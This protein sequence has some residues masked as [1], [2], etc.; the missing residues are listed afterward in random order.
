MKKKALWKDCLQ[1]IRKTFPKFLSIL[2]I[3]FLGIAFFAGIRAT[4]PDMI[5]TAQD[6]YEQQALADIHIMSTMGLTEDD[7]DLL[8]EQ[9]NLVVMPSVSLTSSLVDSSLTLA[10]DRLPNEAINQLTLVEGR[11]PTVS[12]EIVL[13]ASREIMAKY[14]LGDV[15][16]FEDTLE[17]S[18]LANEA[19]TLEKKEFT[20]VGFV[21][22]PIYIQYFDRSIPGDSTVAG[23]AYVVPEDIS[24]TIYSQAYLRFKERP[25]Q[26]YQDVYNDAVAQ[27]IN[28]LEQVLQAQPDKRIEEIK[29][30]AQEEIDKAE[31]T[32]QSKEQELLDAKQELVDGAQKIADGKEEY[33][34]NKQKF[35]TEIANGKQK[36]V[37][38]QQKLQTA[39][40][41]L[42]QSLA[43]YQANLDQLNQS[44]AT[45]EAKEQELLAQKEKITNLRQ[46]LDSM[47]NNPNPPLEPQLTLDEKTTLIQQATSGSQEAWQQ[48][49][50]YY[51][52]GEFTYQEVASILAP[53]ESQI[54]AA[55]AELEQGKI[56]L[57]DGFAQLEN[58]KNQLETAKTS[59]DKGQKELEQGQQTLKEQEQTGRIELQ[60][61]WQKLQEATDELATGQAEYD[62]KTVDA[63]AKIDQAKADINE[64]KQKVADL[65]SPDYYYFDRTVNPGYQ[66]FESNASRVAAIAQVFPVFFFFVAALIS[67]S[68][69]KRMVV[70]QRTIIGI[71]KGLG[72]RNIAIAQKYVMY[73]ILA[74]IIGSVA[75][76]FVGQQLFPRVIFN[77]YKGMYHIGEISVCYDVSLSILSIGL[78]LICTVGAV[79]IALH[80]T[81][82][83]TGA[84]LLRPKPPKTGHRILL[85]KV[86]FVW[87]RMSFNQKITMRNIFRYKGRN[88]MTVLGVAGCTALILTG[89]G[90]K[91]SISGLETKQF[92]DIMHY[93][94]IVAVD[95]DSTPKEYLDLQSQ[96]KE[97]DGI[98]SVA[99]TSFD[100][101][102]IKIP[103]KNN[104]FVNV[105]GV[106][107]EEL[108]Q[109]VTI[110]DAKTKTALSLPDEGVIITEKLAQMLGGTVGQ[111]LILTD[112]S[113]EEYSI[114][115]AGITKNYVEHWLY[116]SPEYYRIVMGDEDSD[117]SLFITTH[118][119]KEQETKIA[120]ELKEKPG[121]ASVHVMGQAVEAFAKT[122][123]S[124]NIVTTVLVIS[125]ALLAFV[126]LY[127]LSNINISERLREL[128]TIK[129]LGFYPKEVSM[130]IFQEMMILLG[131]GILIGFI[132]GNFLLFFVLK[133]AEIDTLLFPIHIAWPSYLY[134]GG[135]TIIFSSIVMLMMHRILKKIKMVEALK[136]ED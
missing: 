93:S 88:T 121:V 98:E 126:V 51:A 134:A 114:Q 80:R 66:E 90:I 6:Y 18:T 36:I 83:E 19:P 135:L 70:E 78:A 39:Q 107:P 2:L 89:F 9:E 97:I 84:Q 17:E 5:K 30:T 81:L 79:W 43:E 105:L 128:S 50:Q 73:A 11:L 3:I 115:I 95:S 42:N 20:V 37:F 24:A 120:K 109:I 55:G 10:I 76:I 53:N 57:S 25:G 16:Q 62:A 96:I 75:G 119:N 129:V 35:E 125:A 92:E 40:Q 111:E 27:E 103:K 47:P 113:G 29:Q 91:D 54:A 110:T 60:N 77:A 69:M 130:Y 61:A 64:A 112:L 22:S 56:K 99:K 1:E 102:E 49:F 123:D 67:F 32:L 87:S 41:E 82:K 65:K 26:A 136:A 104:Q 118:L 132:L 14:Q 127:N 58:A 7:I 15:I 52:I 71:Y 106:A 86:G 108:P 31:T 74:A 63:K 12:G 101:L 131:I 116:M 124:L 94:M 38:N 45:L 28:R 46:Q 44:K 8:A 34:K 133:T 122:V 85:E 23:F 21:H 72:Y 59:I 100:K 33:F 117:N 68:A 48:L 4:G 13:D